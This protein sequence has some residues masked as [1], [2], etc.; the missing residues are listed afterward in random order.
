[1]LE[2]SKCSGKES[3]VKGMVTVATRM[4]R[5]GLI[6]VTCKQRFEGGKESNQA[7]SW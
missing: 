3:T 2:S 4:I 6:K 7:A 5:V 1:M